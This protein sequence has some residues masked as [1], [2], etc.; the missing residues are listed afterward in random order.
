VEDVVNLH[1][2]ST[3]W[4]KDAFRLFAKK[5]TGR[6]G[7]SSQFSIPVRIPAMLGM[8]NIRT[9]GCRRRRSWAP[10]L[11]AFS[12]TSSP[13]SFGGRLLGVLALNLR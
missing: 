6:V 11:F 9:K 8:D 4:K 7:D 3:Q 1:R 12:I 13:P 5:G 2:N 10:K